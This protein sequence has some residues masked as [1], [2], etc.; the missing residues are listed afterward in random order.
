MIYVSLEIV[1]Y[2]FLLYDY[3][4]DKDIYFIYEIIDKICKEILG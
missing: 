2:F 4:L 3:F 1:Y